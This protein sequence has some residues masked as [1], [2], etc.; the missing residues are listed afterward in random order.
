M[1]MVSEDDVHGLLDDEPLTAL[2]LALSYGGTIHAVLNELQ[3]LYDEAHSAAET[4]D[5]SPEGFEAGSSFYTREEIRTMVIYFTFVSVVNEHLLSEAVYEHVF[6]PSAQTEDT[7]EKA[8]EMNPQYCLD[9]LFA[10][11]VISSGVKGEIGQVKDFRNAL[12]HDIQKRL[13]PSTGDDMTTQVE[14][15]HRSVKRLNDLA[16]DIDVESSE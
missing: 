4:I 6:A 16:I 15:A 13:A 11:D 12:M 7:R 1:T 10:A 3:S 9:L 8:Y 14:R 5:D 2:I